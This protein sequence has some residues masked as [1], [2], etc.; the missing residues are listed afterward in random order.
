METVAGTAMDTT[1]LTI[2]GAAFG[3]M[4]ATLTTLMVTSIRFQHRD[5]TQTRQ[6][7]TQASK[8]NRELIEQASKENRVRIEQASKQNCELIEK[9]TG[10]LAADLSEHERVTER[11]HNRVIASL[12]D[13]RE[14]LARIEGH[15]GIGLLTNKD[16]EPNGD[17]SEAA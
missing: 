2:L 6:L 11:N 8:E 1:V 4:F 13:A 12:S 5:S 10:K 14:R 3:V 15:L 7:I 9:A 17:N 16:P